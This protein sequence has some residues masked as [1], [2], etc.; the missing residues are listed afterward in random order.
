MLVKISADFLKDWKI[1]IEESILLKIKKVI[2]KFE[3]LKNK[4]LGYIKEI[5]YIRRRLMILIFS[6]RLTTILKVV[7]Y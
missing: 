6:H 1:L 3:K 5:N 4:L 2:K 7:H